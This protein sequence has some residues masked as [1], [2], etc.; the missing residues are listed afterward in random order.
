[1]KREIIVRTETGADIDPSEVGTPIE[2]LNSRIEMNSTYRNRTKSS[3][4][5]PDAAD[6]VSRRLNSM[7]CPTENED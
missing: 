6:L 2:L 4:Q 5:L 1:L 7:L 3:A